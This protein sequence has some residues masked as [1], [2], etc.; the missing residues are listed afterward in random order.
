MER[1]EGQNLPEEPAIALIA[2]DALGNFAIANLVAQALKSRYP[3]CGLDYYGGSRTL[4]LEESCDLFTWRFS[5]YGA[6]FSETLAAASE[7]PKYVLVVNIESGY[8]SKALAS[9]LAADYVCG[10]CLAPNARG[11]WDFPADERGD[12]WRDRAWIARGIENRYSFL[13]TPF[14]G[15]MF[16]KLCYLGGERGA[17][18]PG[19]I[20]RYK[21]PQRPVSGLPDVL[22]STGGSLP[23]KLWPVQK[24]RELLES[25]NA[26]VGLLGAAPKRQQQF[27][28]SD[29]D[30]T[31]LVDA[32]LAEDWR[33]NLSLPEVV[34]ALE[35]AKLVITIDNGILH[36][37]AANEV[38][39]VGLY[40][41]DFDRLWAPPNPNLARLTPLQGDVDMIQVDAVFGAVKRLASV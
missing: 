31:A 36:F 41:R 12:L 21:F 10:P 26:R 6:P 32:G 9:A 15:E 13:E 7:R 11:D 27:Y 1:W 34:G 30:E 18:W 17:P 33:G 5:A 24:W 40:R 28:H 25:L 19:G 2:N 23:E 16:V 20:P 29:S 3:D 8:P 37:A 22:I 38:P 35:K 39:T 4:E 14:I